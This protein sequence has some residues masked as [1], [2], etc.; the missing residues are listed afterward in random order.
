VEP[1]RTA[2]K[3]L[4]VAA[5]FRAF[6]L[7]LGTIGGGMVSLVSAG[8]PI[9][10]PGWE[11]GRRMPTPR[12]ELACG[13]NEGVIYVA[14]GINLGGSRKEFQSFDTKTGVW[15]RLPSLAINLNHS[16]IACA[17]GKV[18]VSGGFRN[19]RQTKFSNSLFAY[20][21]S[22]RK[23][24]L[25]G[26]MPGFR[27][28]HFMIYRDGY[29]H[30][31]GGLQHC[32]IW[33]YHIDK[34]IWS[35]DILPPFPNLRDHIGVVQDEGTIYVLGGRRDR[36]A[37]SDCWKYSM[38]SGKWEVFTQLPG[39]RGAPTVVMTEQKTIHIA[40]GEDLQTQETYRRHDIYDLESGQWSMGTPLPKARHGMTSALIGGNWYV[41][42]GG[43]KAEIGTV[44]TATGQ[45]DV[46]RLEER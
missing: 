10:F 11:S 15:K 25:K 35:R 32:E 8:E 20:D 3:H 19:L 12:S 29:L 22:K 31:M 40:G 7:L 45:M 21:I 42:G 41:I 9:A 27:H 43:W 34:G 37:Q 23:W 38:G 26:E 36:V 1:Y 17:G 4:Y 28:K 44:F 2:I 24:E 30:L 14:G 18:Y 16:G 39:P 46:L 13:W 33:S 6:V 5:L